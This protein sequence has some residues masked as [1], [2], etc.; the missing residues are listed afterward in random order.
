MLNLEAF[1][2]FNIFAPCYPWRAMGINPV[3]ERC[4]IITSDVARQSTP[5]C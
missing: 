1:L 2:A 3:H 4:S 5:D